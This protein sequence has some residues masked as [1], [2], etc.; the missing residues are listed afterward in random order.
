MAKTSLRSLYP[1]APAPL[2]RTRPRPLRPPFGG[3]KP[4]P[5]PAPPDETESLKPQAVAGALFSPAP[6]RAR[7]EEEERTA[8]TLPPVRSQKGLLGRGRGRFAGPEREFLALF[9]V[10]LGLELSAL[11]L[12]RTAVS[13]GDL[14]LSGAILLSGLCL[15][16]LGCAARSRPKGIRPD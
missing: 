9:A 5:L 14:L 13:E 10:A 6:A 7:K 1:Q 3:D 2:R 11:F 12:D 4:A 15:L 16:A 8:A